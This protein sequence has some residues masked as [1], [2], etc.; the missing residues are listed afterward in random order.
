MSKPG[1]RMNIYACLTNELLIWMN[2]G[3]FHVFYNYQQTGGL[4]H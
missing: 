4:F 1:S 2:C 3:I